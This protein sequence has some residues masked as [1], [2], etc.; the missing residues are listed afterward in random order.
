ML[1]EENG[2]AFRGV[3]VCVFVYGAVEITASLSRCN[4]DA[5]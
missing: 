1:V 4:H 2:I 5:I 3:C